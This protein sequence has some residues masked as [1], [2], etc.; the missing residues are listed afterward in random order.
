MIDSPLLKCLGG[1]ID[2]QWVTD[3]GG[4]GT[5][6]TPVLD[7]ATGGL[8][9][10]VPAMTAQ[11]ATDAIN[12][13]ARAV[14]MHTP[15]IG[16]RRAWLH[17]I[18]DDLLKHRVELARIITL[19]NG[20][21]IEEAK[22]E[23]DY[24]ASF[25]QF[26]AG[27]LEH[28]QPESIPGRMRDC[29]WTVRHRPLGVA[30]LITPWNF[31]LAMLAKKLAAA[32]GA[33]CA[34]VTK[35]A[36]QTPLSAIALWHVLQ[37]FDLEPGRVNLIMGPAEPIGQVF[38]T[39]PATAIVSITGSTAAGRKLMNLCSPQVKRLSLELGGNAPLLVFDDAD[40]EAVIPALIANK[41]RASGQTC[42]CA[43]RILVHRRVLDA[44][45]EKLVP[46]VAALRVG[47]GMDE[48]TDIGPLIDRDAWDKVHE[49][50]RD[51][52]ARGARRVIGGQRP[53][54]TS[55]WSAFYE[56]TVLVG[57]GPD[58]RVCREET[59]G[60]VIAI[61]T[62]EDDSQA[63]RE[64]NSTESG[65]AAYA[66]T[67]DSSRIEKLLDRLNFGH[68]GI[69]TATG[70]TAE[71]PFGGNKQSGYGREGG[72]EGLFEYCASQVVARA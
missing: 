67:Q 30:G 8:L 24:A 38:C 22:G 50:V 72:L 41:F 5:M 68:V 46:R 66:F 61:A 45:L 4:P 60:P 9:A 39:H 2:G 31:P 35:P 62:F 42:V 1:Y 57:V 25:F 3:V 37:G 34:V 47:S 70:P 53:R 36:P 27:K 17:G 63:I 15:S 43:N 10:M 69:N 44:F 59:F 14:Q 18:G 13:A 12:V 58:M 28:L 40:L 21:P 26:M 29:Q 23:V 33:G 54:P 16:Q 56:P 55:D 11:H 51:A 52:I 64:A 6:G 65:L 48:G 49:H 71:A 32:L 7:P 20:K 19:E